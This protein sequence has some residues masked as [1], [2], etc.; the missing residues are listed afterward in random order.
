MLWRHWLHKKKNQHFEIVLKKETNDGVVVCKTQ[1]R[2]HRD[3]YT[4]DNANPF[5]EEKQRKE[6]MSDK[7][8]GKIVLFLRLK[9]YTCICYVPFPLWDSVL[10]PHLWG[11]TTPLWVGESLFTPHSSWRRYDIHTHTTALIDCSLWTLQ[12]RKSSSQFTWRGFLC[13]CSLF[14]KPATCGAVGSHSNRLFD[15][16][17]NIQRNSGPWDTSVSA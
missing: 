4:D 9:I 1:H 8:E 6:W 12:I 15:S 7:E 2:E 17:R 16:G 10:M 3:I 13:F 14:R 11:I 5:R